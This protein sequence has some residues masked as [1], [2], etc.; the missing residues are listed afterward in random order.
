[1]VKIRL[2]YGDNEIELDGPDEFVNKHLE[3]FYNQIKLVSSETPIHI[4]KDILKP[5][6]K[7][8]GGKVP[9]P[10]EFYL[11]KGKTD[12][13]SQILIF[14]KY[15]EQFGHKTEFT[16]AEVQQLAKEAK[17]PKKIHSQNFTYAV[18]QGVLRAHG[19][20][21]YSLTLNAETALK[22]MPE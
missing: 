8:V 16:Q 14:G 21:K 7:S 1:M 22:A 13:V 12:G 11:S 15:L 19:K 4:T 20:G 17:L 9:T 10:A 18:R 5:P 6:S 2:K 3:I